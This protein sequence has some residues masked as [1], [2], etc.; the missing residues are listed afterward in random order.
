MIAI[1]ELFATWSY[2][3]EVRFGIGRI[4]E[5]CAAC[6]ALN[7]KRPLVVTDVGLAGSSIIKELME[8]IEQSSLEVGLFSKVQGNPVGANIEEGTTAFRSGSHD[9]VIAIGG[10]SAMDA[11]KVIA[12]YQGQESK[13]FDLHVKVEGGP[14]INSDSI[15]PVVAVP[16]TAGTGSETGR[17][18]LITEEAVDTKRIFAHPK[19]MPAIVIEDPKLTAG[20]PPNLTAW[21]GIDALAHSFEALCAPGIHPMADGIALEGMRLVKE[22]LP[23]AYADGNDLEARGYMLAAASMGSTAFQ[24]GLGG[25]HSLSHSIGALTI[26]IMV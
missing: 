18:G 20:L 14:K 8:L 21:T 7:I 17:A 24:K 3:T 12:M 11:G 23:R 22:Y 4:A 9:G 13:L 2:P 1:P 25:I 26:H 15:A 16:T 5:I 10:G 19:M 6:S